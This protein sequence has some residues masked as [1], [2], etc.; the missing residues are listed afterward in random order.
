LEA[1][2]HAAPARASAAVM[3]LLPPAFLVISGPLGGGL[4]A[5]VSTPRGAACL[6]AG[7]V[8]DAAG[9]LWMWRITRS[10]A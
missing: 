5:L 3:V 8:L 1:R 2:S 4:G 9:G 7:L 6:G 10:A